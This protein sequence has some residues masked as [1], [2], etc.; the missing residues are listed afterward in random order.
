[1]REHF[2]LAFILF[3]SFIKMFAEY[4][5]PVSLS[6]CLGLKNSMYCICDLLFSNIFVFVIVVG[7]IL[8]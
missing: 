8:Q 6:L 2:I 5:V 1:M 7:N 3:Y 4:F